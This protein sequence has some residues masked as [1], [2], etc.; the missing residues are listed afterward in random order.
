MEKREFCIDFIK[1]SCEQKGAC[2]YAHVIVQDKEVYLKTFETNKAANSGVMF[3][4]NEDFVPKFTLLD[5]KNGGKKR[6][7]TKC[8]ECSKGFYFDYEIER[9]S[10]ESLYC[11]STCITRFYQKQA[12]LSNM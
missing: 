8:K 5:P 1:G 4:E 3:N 11:P 6:W 10:P 9:G 7:M 12:N 2:K